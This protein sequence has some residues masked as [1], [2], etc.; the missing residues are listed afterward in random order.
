MDRKHCVVREAAKKVFF[1]ARLLRGGGVKGLAT[2]KVFS[3]FVPNL[4]QNIF[5]IRFFLG[6]R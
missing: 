4:K 3:Y 1:V 6:G 5:Y 2:K